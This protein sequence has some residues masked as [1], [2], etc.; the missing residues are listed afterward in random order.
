M[1]T[2]SFIFYHPLS[3]SIEDCQTIAGNMIT[4]YDILSSLQKTSIPT[5]TNTDEYKMGLVKINH[6]FIVLSGPPDLSNNT[7]LQQVKLFIDSLIF[8]LG[9]PSTLHIQYS[10]D[11]IRVMIRKVAR[12][13][14]NCVIPD[15]GITF[16]NNVGYLPCKSN[17]PPDC[18]LRFVVLFLLEFVF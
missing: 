9:P 6:Y 17:V 2:E 8:F 12:H 1:K 15:R 7:M 13:I 18:L 14:V 10:A 3:L 5:L 16:R 4:M 11:Q